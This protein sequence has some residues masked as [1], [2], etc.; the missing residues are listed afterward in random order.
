MKKDKLTDPEFKQMVQLLSRYML[1]E[2][3]QWDAWKFNSEYGDMFIYLSMKPLAEE[4][5]HDDISNL[6][7]EE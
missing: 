5:R 2:M 3:D 4:Q 7:E 6:L 1:T